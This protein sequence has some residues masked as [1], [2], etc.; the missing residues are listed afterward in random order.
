MRFRKKQKQSLEHEQ[1]DKLYPRLSKG[2]WR[3]L[4]FMILIAGLAVFFEWSRCPQGGAGQVLRIPFPFSWRL[5]S[6]QPA[7]IVSL[8]TCVQL[9]TERQ[10]LNANRR[11]G[12]GNGYRI[13]S[14]ER[15]YRDTLG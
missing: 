12:N 5:T 7:L 6:I 8:V 1:L 15:Q 13:R 3:G 2:I 11:R 10:W 14:R 4:L 9:V